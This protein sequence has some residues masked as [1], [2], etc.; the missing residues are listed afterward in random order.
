MTLLNNSIL[1]PYQ[2]IGAGFLFNKRHAYLADDMGL[3][4]CIMTLAAC[5]GLQAKRILIVAPSGVRYV[6]A[7][8]I[9]KW[10]PYLKER[11]QIIETAKDVFFIRPGFVIV[12]YDLVGKEDIKNQLLS[13]PPFDVGIADEAHYLK[14]TDSIRTQAVLAFGA[15]RGV[16]SNCHRR[17]L[18]SGTPMRNKPDDLLPVLSA[19]F[20]GALIPSAK[21]VAGFYQ[22][23][24]ETTANL[25]ELKQKIAPYF[26][27]RTKQEVGLQMPSL[28]VQTVELPHDEMPI[29][30]K[31]LQEVEAAECGCPSVLSDDFNDATI[32]S[33]FSKVRKYIS[34]AKAKACSEMIRL[35]VENQKTVIFCWH[36]DAIDALRSAFC[37]ENPVVIDGRITGEARQAEL[38]RFRKTDCPIGIFQMRATGEGVNDLQYSCSNII[39]LEYDWDPFTMQQCAARIYRPGQ[40]NPVQITILY[41]KGTIEDRLIKKL[42]HKERVFEKLVKGN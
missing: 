5:E 11:I 39:F 23:Y 38:E 6:W 12:S 19:L 9:A 33:W 36:S 37:M 14:A 27:R 7:D 16:F 34:T 42:V 10:Y 2:K 35:H 32:Q 30:K 31:A 22:R 20:P 4:K 17:W 24:C 25:G 13:C 28:F 21:S 26:L 15:K 29:L 8:E 41:V 3:G 40:P 18:L 1:R